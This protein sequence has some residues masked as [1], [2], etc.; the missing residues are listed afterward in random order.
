ML[1]KKILVFGL[2]VGIICGGGLVG[3]DEE[4]CIPMGNITLSP[5]ESVEPT[6]APVEFPHGLHF[7]ISCQECHHN[8][9]GDDAVQSCSTSGCHDLE[10]APEKGDEP[11]MYY[12]ASFHH[13]CI[14]CHKEIKAENESMAGKFPADDTHIKP[15]GPT[16]CV[17]CH[18]K[19]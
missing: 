14:R 18:P 7:E 10:E 9:V 13:K 6:R 12:K 8:W 17:E 2:A 4:M 15:T 1:R 5:P 11:I 3:A 19:E 16:G